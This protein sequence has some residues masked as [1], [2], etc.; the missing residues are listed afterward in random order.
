MA[1]GYLSESRPPRWPTGMPTVPEPHRTA[2]V[3]ARNSAGRGALLNLERIDGM[4]CSASPPVGEFWRLISR[5]FF[6]RKQDHGARRI[7]RLHGVALGLPAFHMH[8]KLP[9]ASLTFKETNFVGTIQLQNANQPHRLFTGW[10]R[11]HIRQRTRLSH[12]AS[13]EHDK[14]WE[15]ISTGMC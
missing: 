2:S 11:L 3:G 15:V 1:A 14:K 12:L 5:K 7:L 8:A 13:P 9:L 4:R 10:A 6:R